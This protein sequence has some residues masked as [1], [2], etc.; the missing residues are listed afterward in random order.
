MDKI[1]K[2]PPSAPAMIHGLAILEAVNT[3]TA[4]V[5][6]AALEQ[7]TGAARSTL[8]RLLRILVE[9]GW[10]EKG[11][12]GYISGSRLLS[13]CNP[14]GLSE[15]LQRASQ[16]F[17]ETLMEASGNTAAV[18]AVEEGRNVL[19]GKSVHPAAVTMREIGS[20]QV[21]DGASPWGW[22]MR[23]ELDPSDRIRNLPEAARTAAEQA[24]Q[25]LEEKGWC[26]DDQVGLDLVCRM[27]VPLRLSSEAPLLGILSLGGN[28]LTMPAESRD[29][30]AN[31]L[32]STAQQ[33]VDRI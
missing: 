9:E 19:I 8:I 7:S 22:I 3:S 20:R 24:W 4:P 32:L 15:R 12:G 5:R 18:F 25:D 17:L 6:F 2:N 11:R 31:L 1:K 29:A 13:F 16:P 30:L 28:P 26:M 23:A 21:P 27:G 10:L 14:L 33:I